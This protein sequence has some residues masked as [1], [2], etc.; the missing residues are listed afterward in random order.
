MQQNIQKGMNYSIFMKLPI[1]KRK[2]NYIPVKPSKKAFKG[3]Y[4]TYRYHNT[5]LRRNKLIQPNT[6][7]RK[8]IKAMTVEEIYKTLIERPDLLQFFKAFLELSEL[9]QKVVLNAIL[10]DG[11][12]AIIERGYF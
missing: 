11:I 10:K 8:E 1:D 7:V 3:F 6:S 2:H 12:E 4:I 5:V 9:Q